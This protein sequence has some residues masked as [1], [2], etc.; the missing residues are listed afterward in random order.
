MQ[1]VAGREA[2]YWRQSL[3]TKLTATPVVV[4]Y[5]VEDESGTPTQIQSFD[6]VLVANELKLAGN[7]IEP[8]AGDQI[9]DTIN[10]QEVVFEVL[11]IG[12]RPCFEWED[13]G[14][15]LLRVHTQRVE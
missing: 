9:R 15:I 1:A 7:V 2:E 13:G 10:G 3:S 12:R 11:P 8:R 5:D 6:Y 4:T 14:G